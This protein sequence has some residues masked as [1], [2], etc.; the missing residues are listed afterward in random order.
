MNDYLEKPWNG[1]ESGAEPE[2][3]LFS[4]VRRIWVNELKP[5]FDTERV[6]LLEHGVPS[7]YDRPYITRVLEDHR[8]LE[9]L[10]WSSGEEN[11]RKFTRLLADHIRFKQDYFA[12]RIESVLEQGKGSFGREAE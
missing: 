5:H 4:E 3:D 2:E 7:G 11:I 9:K 12:Y 6:F 1:K 8:S 10:V